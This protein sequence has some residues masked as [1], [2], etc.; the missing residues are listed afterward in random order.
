MLAQIGMEFLVMPS[1]AQEEAKSSEPAQMVQELSQV[2][3][4]AVFANLSVEK[5]KESLVIGADTMVAF[6]GQMLG[7]P[8]DE[9]EA[10]EMLRKLQGNTHQV[11]TGVTLIWQEMDL[12][13]SWEKKQKSFVEET[14]VTMYPMDFQEIQSYIATGEPM[15]KAGAYGIQGRCAAWIEK[16]SGDYSNVVGLPVGRLYQEL[17]KIG[18]WE[19][20]DV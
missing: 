5:K 8:A 10:E 1:S 17:K 16:I 7:K 12:E 3:A 13:G 11:F 14:S 19:G 4:E 18:I 20:M 6:A 15:D 9:K 2:K